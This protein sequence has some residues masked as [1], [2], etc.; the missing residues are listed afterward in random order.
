MCAHTFLVNMIKYEGTRLILVPY[1]Y[2]CQVCG[3]RD[4]TV[5]IV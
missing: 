4:I 1:K 5:A 2:Q 3:K